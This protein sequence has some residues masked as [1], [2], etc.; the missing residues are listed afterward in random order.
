MASLD[1]YEIL[2]RLADLAVPTLA[3]FCF[4][5]AMTPTGHIRRIA[6]K[7]ADPSQQ[8][9]LEQVQKFIPTRA[10]I[11]HPVIKSLRLRTIEL[12]PRRG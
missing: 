5:D 12:V 7:H 6:W 8:L 3:D 11:D 9:F 4:F 1:E 2:H 10:S